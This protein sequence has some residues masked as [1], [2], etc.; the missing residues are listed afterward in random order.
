MFDD[1]KSF[2]A[3]GTKPTFEISFEGLIHKPGAEKILKQKLNI[4]IK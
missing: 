3:D 4:S 1:R 2:G